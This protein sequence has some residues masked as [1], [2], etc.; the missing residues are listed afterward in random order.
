MKWIIAFLCTVLSSGVSYGQVGADSLQTAIADTVLSIYQEKDD[1]S[2]DKSNTSD[3]SIHVLQGCFG[4]SK[5]PNEFTRQYPYNKQR[6][7]L[8]T[9]A[10]IVGYGGTMTA[11]YFAWYKNY[12]QSG[13]HFFNDNHEWKQIDKVGHAYSAYIAGYGS[14]EMWRW[15]GLNRKQRIWIGGM[16]GAV[17]LTAI[18]ILDGFSTEWGW[19]WG[20]FAANVAGSGLLVGQELAWNEQRIRYKFSFHK[21]DYKDP[22][23]NNRADKLFGS[24]IPSRMLKDYNS[25]TYWLSGNLK[26]FFPNSNLPP[27]LNVAVGYGANGMFG[28]ESN[29]A[30]KD[31]V[32]TF[33]RRDIKRY[34]QWYIAPDIDLSR[35]RTNNKILRL[36]FGV[37]N[38]FKFPAPSL[39]LSNGKLQVNWLHF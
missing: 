16:S 26:S 29:L 6:I 22:E 8:I 9:A 7:K 30:I 32:V 19:S 24:S 34:R 11:L 12:P 13:F 14:M 4:C 15:A 18:E 27:W 10:K 33:D 37:L 3:S 25:Q 23:L 35:I 28:A 36:A 21:R 17:Y 39:E 31:G 1:A 2:S 5:A 20:D 38:A